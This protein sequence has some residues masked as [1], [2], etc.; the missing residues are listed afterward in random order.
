MMLHMEFMNRY[1]FIFS[2]EWCLNE[3]TV[4]IWLLWNERDDSEYFRKKNCRFPGELLVFNPTQWN[5]SKWPI[6]L[7]TSEMWYLFGG[8]SIRS[9]VMISE[10]DSNC[11]DFPS[12]IANNSSIFVFSCKNNNEHSQIMSEETSTLLYTIEELNYITSWW[13]QLHIADE[14]SIT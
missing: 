3:I 9:S 13:T 7:E 10:F 1:C 5:L 8:S 11:E 4:W 2:L 12:K 14:T 6:F